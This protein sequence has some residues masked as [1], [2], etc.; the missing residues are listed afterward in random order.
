MP[1][2][3]TVG[4]SAASAGLS[5]AE[6]RHGRKNLIHRQPAG[7]RAPGQERSRQTFD[8]LTNKNDVL[9][10]IAVGRMARD[11]HQN[12]HRKK[13]DETNHS[14]I[15]G[16]SRQ[17]IDVPAYRN[18]RHLAGKFRASARTHVKKKWMVAEKTHTRGIRRCVG[19]HVATKPALLRTRHASIE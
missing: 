8:E 12:R 6:H 10:R 15:E 16:A 1:R 9:P 5:N 2:G 14:E 4:S 13:L 7:H 3:A 17:R 11:E 18:D 19:C